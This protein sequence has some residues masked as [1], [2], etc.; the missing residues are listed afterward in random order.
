MS[1]VDVESR[2][3]FQVLTG[4][5]PAAIAV[6]RACGPGVAEFIRAHLR[7]PAG[8][9]FE[10]AAS[11]AVRRAELVDRDGEPLDQILVSTHAPAPT[12]NLRFHLHGSPFLVRHC[13]ALLKACSLQSA[14][15]QPAALWHPTST[16]EAEAWARLPRLLTLRGARWVSDQA[17]R[18]T[19]FA[20]RLR[21]AGPA[22]E[23]C[24]ACAAAAARGN[25][26]E[27]FT[28]P[29]RVVLAG[30]PNAGKSTLANA[31]ADR[32]VSLVAPTPGTTRD[33]TEITAE[34]DGFPITWIDTAGLRRGTDALEAA[35]IARTHQ[36]IAHADATVVIVDATHDAA[37]ARR[38]FAAEFSDLS[39][40]VVALNK[41]DRP[42]WATHAAADLPA[43]W[44]GQG[45]AISSA[46]GSGLKDLTTLLLERTGRS[47]ATLSGLAA[48]TARQ[49]AILRLL[50]D[51]TDRKSLNDIILELLA[52]APDSAE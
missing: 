16:L 4:A 25:I 6:I 31:L 29:L 41:S 34:A 45:I 44:R 7:T 47:D 42:D 30:P 9:A 19:K 21:Q 35:G 27:Y 36:L 33:W 14:P 18:L 13:T 50:A 15:A 26:V 22:P 11:G 3:T 12:W 28:R 32:P 1:A 5:A 20:A 43:A 39:P 40:A 23:L 17:Q 46:T 10:P 2:G 38:A 49:S 48:L 37:T 52:G 24:A 51:E 8:A